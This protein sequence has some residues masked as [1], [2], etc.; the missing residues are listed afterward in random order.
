MR[1]INCPTRDQSGFTLLE[2]LVTLV[3]LSVG[4]LLFE[5]SLAGSFHGI[6]A[7]D[8]RSAA[9]ALALRKLEEAGSEAPLAQGGETEGETGRFRWSLLIEPAETDTAVSP[10][11]PHEFVPYWVAVSVR[12]RDGLLSTP[13]SV[14]FRRLKL[15]RR[16]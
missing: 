15:E 13:V 14:H 3:I 6:S 11:D 9:V 8:Q 7:A 10:V 5:R 12:W 2:T 4:V 1:T 16:P